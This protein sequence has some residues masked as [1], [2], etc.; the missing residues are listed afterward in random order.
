[1]SGTVRRS[2]LVLAISLLLWG[3]LE[4]PALLRVTAR[5]GPPGTKTSC[6]I[7]AQPAAFP[8]GQPAAEAKLGTEAQKI[9]LAGSS[10]TRALPPVRRVSALANLSQIM[11][12]E[13]AIQ[14]Y[15][16]AFGVDEELV[17]AV[18]RRESGFNPTAV[19]PKGAMGLMQLMPDT[20]AM[21]GV[22]N[23]FD[24]EQN[25]AGGIKYLERCLN[26]FHGD[27]GLAL[28]AYN[29]GP[30][31]VIKYQGCPPFSETV[32]YVAAVLQDYGKPSRARVFD[33]RLH[34]ATVPVEIPA[35]TKDSG[36]CWNLPAPKV[37]TSKPIWHI[38]PTRWRVFPG[39]TSR[40]TV[41]ARSSN[42][43]P[44]FRPD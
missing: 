16:R 1:M 18:V 6:I 34:G 22:T 13:L 32:Q 27:V 25:I 42:L 28:A 26:Q 33:L 4:A 2:V 5:F 39:Q 10:T 44:S 36:P 9:G 41:T 24:V 31:N 17:W 40:P 43:S 38:P 12:M 35:V 29:A 14:K 23:P 20:A 15:A 11:Q 19:S 3:T 37:K 30:E 7:P 21:M 8:G